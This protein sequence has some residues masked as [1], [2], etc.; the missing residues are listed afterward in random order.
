MTEPSVVPNFSREN[1]LEKHKTKLSKQNKNLKNLTKSTNKINQSHDISSLIKAFR[2]SDA[3]ENKKIKKMSSDVSKLYRKI[4]KMASDAKEKY[5]L[6]LFLI[7]PHSQPH[8]NFQSLHRSPL[9]D[10]I[11]I[12]DP[13]L[14]QS[15]L[16]LITKGKSPCPEYTIKFRDNKIPTNLMKKLAKGYQ[17]DSSIINNSKILLLDSDKFGLN[18]KNLPSVYD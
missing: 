3:N 17:N 1:S 13:Y 7:D 11:S 12:I 8:S 10:G 5:G 18:N 2:S 14:H 16:P 15:P 4:N 6:E 9:H